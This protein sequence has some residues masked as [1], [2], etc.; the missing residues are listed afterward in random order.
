MVSDNY[1]EKRIFSYLLKR[2][3]LF[4][5]NVS[6]LSVIRLQAYKLVSILKLVLTRLILT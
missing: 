4:I 6:G 2:R 5:T 1:N 3:S